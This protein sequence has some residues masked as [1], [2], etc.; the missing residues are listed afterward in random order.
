MSDQKLLF[1]DIDN[2]LWN[3]DNHIPE[4][5]V[6][7]IRTARKAG[8]KAFICSGRCRGYIQAPS[9]LGIGFDGIVSGCGTMIED[10][11]RNEILF[12]HRMDPL[13]TEHTILTC[14]SFGYKPILEGREYLY[15]DDADFG[16]DPYGHKLIRELGDHRRGIREEWGR[17]ECSKLSCDSSAGDRAACH[18][19]LQKDFHFIIHNSSVVE[20]VPQGYTKGTGVLKVCELF[21][22]DPRDT[23]SF[24]D[25]VND[26]EML[27]TTAESVV[28]GGG[29]ERAKAVATYITD[30]LMQDGIFKACRRLGLI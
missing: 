22:V 16:Q 30:D 6:T 19:A 9:L 1:F 2:T 8:H 17:W 12:Y 23:V 27:Q 13:L 29:D 5:T 20:M 14:R 25:S 7:A 26:L 21:G 11:N 18:E 15:F 3:R 28:M 24:G 10:L 4:S